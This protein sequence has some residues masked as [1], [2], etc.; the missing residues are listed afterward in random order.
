LL[1]EWIDHPNTLRRFTDESRTGMKQ[2][3]ITTAMGKRLIGKGMA[4]HPV[5]KNVLGAGTLVIIGGTT[6]GYVAEEIL[7][8]LGVGD[9]FSRRGFRRGVTAAPGVK[10]PKVD[11]PGDVVI[12]RGEWIKGRTIQDTVDEL[13]E[14]DVILKGGNAFDA[15]GQAAVQIGSSVGGTAWLALSAV[16]GRRVYLMVPIG[17]EKRVLEDVN[18]L[19]MRCNAPGGEGPGLLPL[20]APIFTELDAIKLLTGADAKLMAAGGVYGAEGASW[21]TI[22]GSEQEIES[23]VNLVDSV[24][25]EPACEA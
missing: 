17:L 8:S 7:G 12:R 5:I 11:F 16:I 15:R 2:V 13:N 10:A 9:Q 14:G 21:L 24:V 19:A 1:S 18:V 6:N 3:T 25:G 20:P 23:A 4:Q 22:E